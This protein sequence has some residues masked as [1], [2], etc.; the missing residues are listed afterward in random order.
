MSHHDGR[1]YRRR[2]AQPGASGAIRTPVSVL[3]PCPIL[4]RDCEPG[5]GSLGLSWCGHD[6]GDQQG[7]RGRVASTKRAVVRFHA[8]LRGELRLAD[9]GR[10]ERPMF[11]RWRKRVSSA[12]RAYPQ[13]AHWH[14]CGGCDTVDLSDH[15]GGAGTGL[16]MGGAQSDSNDPLTR[17]PVIAVRAHCVSCLRS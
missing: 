13:V 8:C 5:Q 16:R 6:A 14:S 12:H 17:G 15:G 2:P 3:T 7:S 11:T 10:A 1:R 9:W 4:S